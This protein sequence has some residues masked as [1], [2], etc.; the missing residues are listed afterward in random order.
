MSWNKDQIII[1]IEAYKNE[2]TLYAIKNPN[3]HNKH[4]RNEALK[5]AKIK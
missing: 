1:L 3:Y 4:L 2:F 5:R